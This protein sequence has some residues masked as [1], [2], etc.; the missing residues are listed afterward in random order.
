MPGVTRD[1]RLVTHLSRGA[2]AGG[3]Y[4]QIA[5]GENQQDQHGRDR[6]RARRR[7]GGSYEGSL[8]NHR[9][10]AIPYPVKLVP[11]RALSHIDRT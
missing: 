9:F 8:P 11:P 10:R 1:E 2:R 7:S 6:S 3:S 4:D 5:D